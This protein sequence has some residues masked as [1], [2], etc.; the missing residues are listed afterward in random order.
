MTL[1]GTPQNKHDYHSKLH[2]TVELNYLSS[3]GNTLSALQ[4][5]DHHVDIYKV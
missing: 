5:R 2:V 3:L 1:Y 4:S